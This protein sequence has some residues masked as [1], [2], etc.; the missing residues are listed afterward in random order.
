M[1]KLR[2]IY[3]LLLG[4]G[5]TVSGA[6]LKIAVSV[7]PL[8]TVVEAIGGESVEAHSLQREGDSCSVF[9]PRPSSVAWLAGAEAF[10]RTGVDYET[11]LM[12]K[13]EDRFPNLKIV[14]LRPSVA[15]EEVGTSI[16]HVHGPGCVHGHEGA[17]DT[18]SDTYD[19]VDEHSHE[20]HNH[21]DDHV[22][23]GDHA[24]DHDHHHDHDHSHGHFPDLLDAHV[25]SGDSHLWLDPVDL[26]RI[27]ELIAEVIVDLRPELADQVAANLKAFRERAAGLDAEI[28]AALA[29]YRGRPF[30]I[31]HPALTLY[32][33]RYGLEQLSI[34]GATE[35]GPR[36]LAERM[37]AARAEGIR[38]ILVQP[39]EN[40]RQAEIVAAAIDASLMEV[41]PMAR[42]WETNLR[43]IT[44]AML[45]VFAKDAR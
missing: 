35:P 33:E 3:I 17:P 18:E 43:D 19:P 26:V 21:H 5:I 14:D 4:C 27:G 45:E 28:S 34:L 12:H 32:A 37:E 29:P 20:G 36:G 40:R 16:G 15:V 25:H 42:D 22:H 10:L 6:P 24:H 13:I 2:I 23:D 31:Y 38:H 8:E 7:L 39:Q 30:M 1:K 44:A 9:E 41:D 11:V